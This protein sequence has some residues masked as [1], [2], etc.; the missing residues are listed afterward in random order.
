M[1][2]TIFIVLTI[3]LVSAASYWV[4]KD[5]F[6]L[7]PENIGVEDTSQTVGGINY[8]VVEVGSDTNVTA[9]ADSQ[10]KKTALEIVAM[11]IVFSVEKS[12][13]NKEKIQKEI[14][15]LNKQISE[16]YNHLDLLID[17]GLKRQSIGDYAGAVKVWEFAGIVFPKNYITFQNLGFAYGFYLKDYKLS[18]KNYL[19]SLE[20]DP[21]NTQ[22]YLDLVDIYNFSGQAE[23]IPEFLKTSLKNAGNVNEAQLKVLLAKYYADIKDN[24]NAIKYYEE[25]LVID[26]SNTVIKQEIERLK[27][28][29]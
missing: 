25:A 26:P 24:A 17:L 15:E 29:Q 21:T 11:P 20:N 6:A 27:S 4:Y 13:A 1:K 22:V 23:K 28:L 7:K 10:F 5:F 12:E 18:E 2:K 19:I 8:E 16:N 3:I 9:E 14:E